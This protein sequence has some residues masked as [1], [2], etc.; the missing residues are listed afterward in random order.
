ME[1]PGLPESVSS[2]PWWPRGSM[3]RGEEGK[4]GEQEEVEGHGEGGNVLLLSI[5]MDAFSTHS[6]R[7]TVLNISLE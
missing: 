3:G 6:F 4:V 1:R 2:W 7:E 5:M